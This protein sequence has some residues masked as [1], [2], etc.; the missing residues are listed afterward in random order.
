MLCPHPIAHILHIAFLPVRAS[1]P[2]RSSDKR[3]PRASI[4]Q[5][6]E[7]QQGLLRA[8]TIAERLEFLSRSQAV[9]GD[10]TRL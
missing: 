10:V 6:M 4:K 2:R 5:H 9:P 1:G 7:R 8:D 3:G